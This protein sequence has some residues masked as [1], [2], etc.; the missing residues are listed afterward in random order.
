MKVDRKVNGRAERRT[1]V[2]AHKE[3]LS[4]WDWVS[5]STA[6]GSHGGGGVNPPR[7]S[8]RSRTVGALC[9]TALSSALF[10][11]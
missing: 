3:L 6:R 2:S 10:F 7:R 1:C 11:K 8:R 5:T 9:S 4:H